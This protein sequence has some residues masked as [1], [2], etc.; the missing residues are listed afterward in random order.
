MSGSGRKT[1]SKWDSRDEPEFASYSVA[2]RDSS[3][4]SNLERNDKLNPRMGFSGKEPFSGG[5]GPSKDDITNKDYRV[6]DPTNARDTDGS[7]SMEM[8][9]GPEDCKNKYSQSPKNGWSRSVRSNQSRSRSRSPPRSFRRDLGVNDRYRMRT[10]PCR[11]FAAGKCR[12]G[13]QCHFLHHDNQNYD[14]WESRHRHDGTPR[15]SAPHES[16]DYS[17]TSGR[18]NDT[19]INYA[20]GRCR[21]G[22]SCKY[23]HHDNSDQFS[24]VDEST[25]ERE[26]DRRRPESSFEHVGRYSTNQNGDIPCKFFAFGNC[27]NGKH[28]RFSHDWQACGSPNR[29]FGD[30]RLRSSQGGDQA[31]DRPKLSDEVSPN[32]RLR[33]DRWGLDGST[34]DENK[35]WGG[36][37]QNDLVVVSNIAKLVEDNRNFMGT[38]EPGFP[39]WPISD[40]WDHSLDK[41]R[42]HDESPFSSDMKEANWTAKND[43]SNVHTSQSVG[44][45]IW[46]GNEKMSPDWNYGVGSSTHIKEEHGQS[47]QQVLPGQVFHQN[48]NALH[49]S[50]CL[51]IGQSQGAASIV[52]PIVRTVDDI[53][54]QEVSAEKKYIVE[55]TIQD[56]NVSQ[57]SS[58]NPLTQNMVSK[59]QLAQLTNLSASL[60]HILGAGQQLPQLYATSISLDSK[61]TPFLSKTEGSDNPVSITFIKPDPAVG[62]QKQYDPK[63]N[64][65]EPNNANSNGVPS[66]SSPSK[67]IPKDT[68]EIPS[69]LS[70]LGQHFDE[71][72]SKPAFSEEQ[73]VKS[74]HSVQLQKGENVE[75]NKE[76][77]VVAEEKQSSSCENKITEENG[78]MKNLD[79]NSGPDEAKKTKDVKGIRAFKFSLVEFVKELLKPTWKDGKIAKED[80]KAIVK[81][82]TDKVTGTVQ[83]GHIP[84][85]QEKIDRYLSLSKPKVNKLIQAYVE[86][87][88]KA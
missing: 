8:S 23:V 37:K 10:Q 38:P 77:K 50:S 60:A 54:N 48:V 32:G 65:R 11:D 14:G 76:N 47:K 64:S 5:R 40:G 83:R 85:T 7:Y 57:V 16:G 70:K 58:R 26:I 87:V 29:R 15:Y 21:M 28:C 67:N 6:L 73:F 80:Y 61:D 69:L 82:V 53:P 62:F 44:S 49:S 78:P 66:T 86:K 24:S 22:A 27:R 39:A 75:V 74:E 52:P 41:N 36:S 51:A 19:C 55:P 17:R 68:A 72:N 25:R 1:S 63:C 56:V 79:Q 20:K 4:W 42:V 30:D 13:S 84:Q 43:S 35:V 31:L 12:R 71:S 45:D 88:Q 59:E 33:D 3:K 9:P 34:A 2:S 81:K 18:S 46:P